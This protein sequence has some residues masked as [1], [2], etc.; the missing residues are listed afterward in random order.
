MRKGDSAEELAMRY[1]HSKEKNPSKSELRALK[2]LIVKYINRKIENLESFFKRSM[3]KKSS[4]HNKDKEA[5]STHTRSVSIDLSVG[6]E[7]FD[8]NSN[9]FFERRKYQVNRVEKGQIS[10]NIN[11]KI[12]DVDVK[13][14]DDPIELAKRTLLQRGLGLKHLDK[15]TEK[16]R[17]FKREVFG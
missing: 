11:N 13:K 1:F 2:A 6:K 16:I 5:I 3:R 15:L 8:P 14:R 10:L 4:Y 17:I 7:N 12:V 9:K